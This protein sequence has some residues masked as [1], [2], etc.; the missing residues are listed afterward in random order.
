MYRTLIGIILCLLIVKPLSACDGCGCS[1]SQSYFGLSP[2]SNGHYVGFW[3]Q[4][5]QYEILPD[6]L[7]PERGFG[8]DY[9]NS[10]ELRARISLSNRIQLSTILPY[11]LHQRERQTGTQDLRGLGDAIL[12]GNYLLFD[13]SDSLNLTLRHRLVAGI[14]TKMPTG[15]YRVFEDAAEANP[16]FQTG[17][18]SWDALFNL[19]YT[20]RWENLGMHIEGTYRLNGTNESEYRFGDRVD[21]AATLYLIQRLR[22]IQ[23][24]PTIGVHFEQADWDE[25]RGYYHTYTGGKNLLANLGLETYWQDYNLGMSYSLP[26]QQNWN[27]EELEAESRFSVHLNYFF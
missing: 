9:F 23:L 27:N 8:H 7:F 18:G 20:L 14:G 17:T 4:H 11:A 25:D 24:M 3:W 21:V 5:Q 1:I 16:N 10:L 12:I 22:S 19:A 26:V 13:N 6:Q 15:N 2:N